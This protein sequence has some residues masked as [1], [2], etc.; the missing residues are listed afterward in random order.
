VQS[1]VVLMFCRALVFAEKNFARKVP[2][3][4]PGTQE[5][6]LLALISRELKAYMTALEN[7][8]LRDGIRH[9]LSISR[10]GNQYMQLLQPWVL[11]KGSDADRYVLTSCAQSL[12]HSEVL[13]M[14]IGDV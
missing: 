8:K 5:W 11:L 6:T 2:D 13:L 7:A 9:I 14:L 1:I 4:L 10:H 12:S 3:M